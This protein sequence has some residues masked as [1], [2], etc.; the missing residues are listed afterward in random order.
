M[1]RREIR[2]ELS[3]W[4]NPVSAF[5]GCH[6]RFRRNMLVEDL[7]DLEVRMTTSTRMFPITP[8]V[9]TML[10]TDGDS[11]CNGDEHEGDDN[12]EFII[13]NDKLMKI[14]TNLT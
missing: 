13:D 12:D 8:T 2:K 4:F 9:S 11:D 1:R 14:M 7:I 6:L 3:I 10:W 5:Q